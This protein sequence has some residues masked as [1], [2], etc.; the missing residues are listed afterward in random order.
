MDLIFENPEEV[1]NV[2]RYCPCGYHPTTY[3]V[4]NKLG[5]E[6]SSTVWLA[7]NTL[8]DAEYGALK[9]LTAEASK[10]T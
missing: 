2:D 1:E 6:A 4:L 9:I 7:Q 8:I 5:H 10:T 3:V